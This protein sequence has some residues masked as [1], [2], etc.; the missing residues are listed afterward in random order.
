MS[1]KQ[2]AQS[3][4]DEDPSDSDS[5][6]YSEEDE[7]STLANTLVAETKAEEKDK[8]TRALRKIR[9]NLKRRKNTKRGDGCPLLLTNG[10]RAGQRCNRRLHRLRN[11]SFSNLCKYHYNREQL[12]KRIASKYQNSNDLP[13]PPPPV[14]LHDFYPTN[15]IPPTTI[16]TAGSIVGG[17]TIMNPVNNTTAANNI[18]PPGPLPTANIPSANTATTIA[19]NAGSIDAGGDTVMANADF[20]GVSEQE[21]N[22]LV[23]TPEELEQRKKEFA[24][25]EAQREREEE[26]RLIDEFME[27]QRKRLESLK[28][29][30]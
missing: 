21:F 16:A 20:G 8:H 15:T 13:P 19:N 1:S 28:T 17:A 6:Y 27:R 18:P 14:T 23:A 11:G 4:L 12:E 2:L 30:R 3:K 26:Q 7:L 9:K 10:K 5:E 25:K 24:E 22:K 29:H